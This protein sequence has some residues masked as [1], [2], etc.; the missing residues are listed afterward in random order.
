MKIK[1]WW[2]FF[3]ENINEYSLISSNTNKSPPPQVQS[4]R[5]F[6]PRE[7]SMVIWYPSQPLQSVQSCLH[8]ARSPSEHGG[9]PSP[10]WG[11]KTDVPVS[12]QQTIWFAVNVLGWYLYF[13]S[14]HSAASSPGRPEPSQEHCKS[15]PESTFL[16]ESF[17]QVRSA[18]SSYLNCFSA[19]DSR[20]FSRILE[21]SD[22]WLKQ[23]GLDLIFLLNSPPELMNIFWWPSLHISW[24]QPAVRNWPFSAGRGQPAR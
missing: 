6:I 22:C 12:L 7:V 8:W 24:L 2:S 3:L 16:N 14:R 4:W 15:L 19:L 23:C 1:I 18:R 5:Y 21:Q 20:Y 11:L 17:L 13:L 9:R 10:A